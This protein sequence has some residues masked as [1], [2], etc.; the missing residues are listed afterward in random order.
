MRRLAKRELVGFAAIWLSLLLG[1]AGAAGGRAKLEVSA[2]ASGC[3]AIE[4]AFVVLLDPDRGMLLLSGAEFV[5][6]HSLGQANGGAFRVALPQSG[7]WE[8]SRAGSPS[9]PVEIWGAAYRGRP[10]GIGGCVSFDREGFSA[11][12]DLVSH[13]Q[14]LVNE[15]YLK[16]PTAERERFPALH[17]ADRVVRLRLKPAG[18]QPVVLQ[19][20]E[21]ATMALRVPGGPQTLLL[22]PFV[23]DEAT[24][25]VA[26]ELSTTDQPY[27]QAAK[28]RSLGFIVASVAQPGTLADPAMTIQ[29]ETVSPEPVSP[30]PR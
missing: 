8:L 10:D 5:G 19:D 18:S 12:G 29:V 14:W 15:V 13:A 21:G 2:P 26:I 1:V 7:A 28:K 27:F 6:G 16:L 3:P 11:E 20:T 9:G 24:G 4:G 17:L 25:R 30:G 23:L 22:R